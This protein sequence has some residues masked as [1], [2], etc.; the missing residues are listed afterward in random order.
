LGSAGGAGAAGGGV[1]RPE[2]AEPGRPGVCR[3]PRAVQC[4]LPNVADDAGSSLFGG[5]W[6]ERVRDGLPDPAGR[7]DHWA[8]PDGPGDAAAAEASN[9]NQFRAMQNALGMQA[10]RLEDDRAQARFNNEVTLA[11]QAMK[12]DDLGLRQAESK[13]DRALAGRQESRARSQLVN[14]VKRQ[15]APYTTRGGRRASARR[16]WARG[17]A[18][19]RN[20]WEWTRGRAS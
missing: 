9:T 4:R 18:A 6:S 5:W 3:R 8:G 20:S 1:A 14:D 7:D 2:H 12:R 19:W 13:I 17:W 11:D 10:A 15:A 16:T